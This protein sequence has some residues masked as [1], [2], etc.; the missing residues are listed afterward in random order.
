MQQFTY[1][2][3][4][5]GAQDRAKQFMANDIVRGIVELVTNSDAAYTALGLK[6]P[7]LRSIAIFVNTS[8]RWYFR[9][10]GQSRRYVSSG[11]ERE[12]H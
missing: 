2:I 8:A 7:K 9:G 5:Q 6:Q 10:K 4:A 11:R 12:I 1:K 3:G